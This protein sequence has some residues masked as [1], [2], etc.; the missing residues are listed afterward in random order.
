MFYRHT[1]LVGT[2]G[3][4]KSHTFGSLESGVCKLIKA[5]TLQV[6]VTTKISPGP[7]RYLTLVNAS[8]LPHLNY[9][10]QTLRKYVPS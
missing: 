8:L 6:G 4:Q 2:E 10:L 5:V 3:A 1:R 7:L 9:D